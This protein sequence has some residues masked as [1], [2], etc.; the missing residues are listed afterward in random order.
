MDYKLMIK[1]SKL[2]FIQQMTKVEIAHK[3]HISRFKVARLLEQARNKGIVRIDIIDS[4]RDMSEM[5][6]KLEQKLGLDAV[7]VM[8]ASKNSSDAELLK[9]LGQGGSKLL[10]E[11]IQDNDTIGISWG[12]TLS[13]VE[14]AMPEQSGFKNLKMVQ[15]TGGMGQLNTI[16][17][18]KLV[19]NMAKKLNAKSSM[20][21]T[22]I[23]VQTP[24]AKGVL[25]Q[26]SGISR[27]Y[28]LFKNINLALIGIGSWYPRI[29][30]NLAKAGF[31]QDEDIAMLKNNGVVADIFSHFVDIKGNI[32][33]GP[34]ENRIMSIDVDAIRKISY[35]I[36]VAG[37]PEKTTA[38]LGAARSGLIKALVTD[39]Y[40]A[41]NILNIIDQNC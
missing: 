4:Q 30:S 2:F 6:E 9:I 5:E 10:L 19:D 33:D 22:P 40:T 39:S 16:D 29:T 15:I 13:E 8:H 31:F 7:I 20:L 14:R 11:T 25:L 27:T 36:A 26:D 21:L 28:E 23:L 35:V 18:I 17:G 38:I 1:A 34:L 41:E 3:L 12:A 37:G 32:V 24:E